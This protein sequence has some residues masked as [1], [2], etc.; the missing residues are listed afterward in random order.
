MSSEKLT[1]KLQKEVAD[2]LKSNMPEYVCGVVKER[3]EEADRLEKEN[4][5]LTEENEEMTAK[6]EELEALEIQQEKLDLREQE[7]QEASKNLQAERAEFER[8]KKVYE[9]EQRLSA[10][11]QVAMHVMEV[12]GNL[13]RNLDFRRTIF[14][15]EDIV[16]G[17]YT[18]QYG[19]HMGPSTTGYKANSDETITESVE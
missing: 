18:D 5:R 13:T 1:K 15:S 8:N 2:V 10:K 17:G 16:D 19:S 4:K 11:E 12:N 3:L 7:Q 6:I 9:L 14:K